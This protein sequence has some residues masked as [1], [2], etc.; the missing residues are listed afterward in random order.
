[1]CNISGKHHFTLG[2]V[3][4]QRP[5][6]LLLRGSGIIRVEICPCRWISLPLLLVSFCIHYIFCLVSHSSTLR[7]PSSPIQEED[8]E[9]LSEMSDAQPHTMLSSSPAPTD[10]RR[11]FTTWHLNFDSAA[12]KI[13]NKTSSS[14]SSSRPQQPRTWQNP[15]LQMTVSFLIWRSANGSLCD[16]GED[17]LSLRVRFI[18]IYSLGWSRGQDAF[19]RRHPTGLQQRTQQLDQNRERPTGRLV[20][21]RWEILCQQQRR[22]IRLSRKI[23]KPNRK[24]MKEKE[25]SGI[26]TVYLMS[27]C[28]KPYTV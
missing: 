20:S 25:K 12:N 17:L 14:S 4:N 5:L 13:F 27:L 3:S 16:T 6:S 10:V 21:A 22:S 18:D 1:M 23:F 2:L 11:H 24:E 26:C 15:C 8:E 19:W 9:K 28:I 7:S